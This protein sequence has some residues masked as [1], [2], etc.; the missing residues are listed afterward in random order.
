MLS[1]IDTLKHGINPPNK[2]NVVVEIPKGSSIKYEINEQSGEISVDR[3]LVPTMFYPCN[4][5]FIPQNKREKMI[6]RIQSMYSYLETILSC[7]SQWLATV[8][9]EYC[10]PRIKAASIQRL[11]QF[12][13]Q[14]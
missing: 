12:Q 5:G 14:R 1:A 3:I 7:P 6:G 2:I 13:W 10:Q 9:L 8:P 11:L 4:Y